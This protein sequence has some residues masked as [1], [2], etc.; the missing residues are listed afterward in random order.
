MLSR[1]CQVTFAAQTVIALVVAKLTRRVELARSQGR[2]RSHTDA[3]GRL[4]FVA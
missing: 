4:I 2:E 3:Y 1:R